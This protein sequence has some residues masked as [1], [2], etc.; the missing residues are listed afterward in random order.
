MPEDLH[1]LAS[2]CSVQLC[3]CWTGVKQRTRLRW[4]P[5]SVPRSTSRMLRTPRK[6]AGGDVNAWALGNCFVT[7]WFS[8]NTLSPEP[9]QTPRKDCIKVLQAFSRDTLTQVA[10]L[11]WLHKKPGACHERMP[12][13]CLSMICCDFPQQEC[14]HITN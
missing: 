12:C 9:N 3:G 2:F 1:H 11:R 4:R 5:E 13:T 7:A 6:E 14:T 8:R 10:K